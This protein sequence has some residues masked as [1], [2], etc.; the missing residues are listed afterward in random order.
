[1]ASAVYDVPLGGAL[2]PLRRLATTCCLGSGAPGGLFAPTLAIGALLGALLGHLAPGLP[3]GTP[4]LLGAA[5]FPAASTRRRCRCC[6]RLPAPRRR[7]GGCSR[8]RSIPRGCRI[9][10]ISV[11]SRFFTLPR[12]RR[13]CGIVIPPR[14]LAPL[15]CR[16]KSGEKTAA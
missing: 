1:M 15:T 11:P 16:G 2:L 3:A 5:G 12:R 4:A 9:G 7:R 10:T 8:A 6:S 14:E 13:R